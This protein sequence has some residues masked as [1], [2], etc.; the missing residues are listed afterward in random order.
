[1]ATPFSNYND[2]R[3]NKHQRKM[4]FEKYLL[5]SGETMAIDVNPTPINARSCFSKP[6]RS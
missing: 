4:G 6:C 1:M 3:H 5:H 2:N